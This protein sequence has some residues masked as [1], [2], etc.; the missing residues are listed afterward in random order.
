[1]GIV[2]LNSIYKYPKRF[3]NAINSKLYVTEYDQHVISY[4]EACFSKSF[5]LYDAFL[6]HFIRIYYGTF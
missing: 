4:Q 5:G 3:L 2:T 1:M 6:F